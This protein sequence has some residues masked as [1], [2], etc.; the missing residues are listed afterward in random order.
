MGLE[1]KV[2]TKNDYRILVAEDAVNR[3]EKRVKTWGLPYPINKHRA[4]ELVHNLRSIL[5]R[6]KYSFLPGELLVQSNELRELEEKTRELAG[7][8]LPRD[9]SFSKNPRVQLA[10]DE[11]KYCL[12]ILLGLRNRFLRG[13]DNKPEYAVDIIGVE[14]V[15]VQ[16]HPQARNLWILKAGT[17]KYGFTV[18]TNIAGVKKGE[19]RGVVILPPVEFLGV[20]S[21]AMIA[22]DPLSIEYKG[23][24]VPYD[25]VHLGEVRN[26]VEEIVRSIK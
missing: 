16:K 11:L 9:K 7:I 21:E 15:S 6:L 5:Y 1:A 20:V 2:D 3:L 26:K 19:V 10:L 17:E 8:I 14:I 12:W 24:P 25:K 13:E 4:L 22:S 23:K 18:I